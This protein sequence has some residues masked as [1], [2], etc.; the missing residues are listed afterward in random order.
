MR[1]K[2]PTP[3]K[4]LECLRFSKTKR[5]C[6][7]LTKLL[8]PCWAFIDDKIEYELREKERSNYTCFKQS[9]AKVTS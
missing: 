9:I 7:V 8:S 1:K 5:Q 3:E 6:K 4:C 2:K